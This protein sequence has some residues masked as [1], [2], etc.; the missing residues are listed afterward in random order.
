MGKDLNGKD[1]GRGYSQRP[2]GRYEARTTFNGVKIDLYDKSLKRLRQR[3]VF[4][5]NR[6]LS[7]TLT[8]DPTRTLAEWYEEWFATYKSPQLKSDVASK[9]YYRKLKNTFVRI[10][11]E[12]LMSSITVEDIQTATNDLR[13]EGYSRRGINEALNILRKC[14]DTAIANRIVMVNPATGIMVGSDYTPPNERRVLTHEEQKIFLTET[15]DSYYREA[16]RI[17]LLTGMRI[18]EFSGLQ[19]GDVDFVNKRIDIRHSMI[20]AYQDG[21]KIEK[22]APPKSV[23][24]YRKIPFFGG[25]EQC[26]LTW[27]RKQDEYKLKLGGRWRAGEEFGD[28]VFTTTLGSPV[29]RYNIVHD[30][31]RVEN[32]IR[33]KDYSRFGHIYPHAF[34][35]TFATRCFEKGLDPVFIQK[36]MGHSHYS[37][38]ISYTHILN[39]KEA[40]EVAKAGDLL[41]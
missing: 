27:K 25:V 10:L 24:S 40:E 5:R 37:T 8:E 38:T 19:W 9:S 32:N 21:K 17:L 28:L 33:M 39:E 18:G 11:G 23:N 1:I 20:T 15:E 35:H 4:E 2:D 34:R 22:L 12:K 7:L 31:Q 14:I 6:L 13:A 26:F 30:I 41:D 3:F 29:T 36:I 16:Y